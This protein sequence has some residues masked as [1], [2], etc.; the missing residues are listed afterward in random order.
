MSLGDTG[1]FILL[2]NTF[3]IQLGRRTTMPFEDLTCEG[4]RRGW[5]SLF[6]RRL[7]NAILQHMARH[8]TLLAYFY[9][10]MTWNDAPVGTIIA[11]KAAIELSKFATG[12]T[13]GRK[14]RCRARHQFGTSAS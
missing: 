7:T 4:V 13:I 3:G 5:L 12:A 14:S 2:A 8:I 1:G 11:E 9:L 10:L 6:L